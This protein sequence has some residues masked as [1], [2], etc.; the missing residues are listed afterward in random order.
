MRAVAQ[1]V[2][3]GSLPSANPER[4]AALRAHQLRVEASIQ[5]LPPATRKELSDLLALLGTS[6][7]RWALCGLRTAW[8]DAPVA[9]VSAAL[10]Q[11]R[12]SSMALRRQVYQALRELSSAAWFAGPETWV[13]L[14]YPGPAAV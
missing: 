8:A 2:L 7:G 14:G 9:D 10:S 13:Q 4:E 3:E 5:G 1:A 6:A 11:M 12:F